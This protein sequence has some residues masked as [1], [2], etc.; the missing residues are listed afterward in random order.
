[1]S[2]YQPNLF[3]PGA[4]KSGTTT[5]HDLLNFH[6]DICMSSNKEPGYW[7]DQLLDNYDDEKKEWYSNLFINK[8]VSITGESSTSYMF[9]PGFIDNIKSHYKSSPKFIFILRN[10][11]DRCYSHFWWM[12]GLGL[13]K[14]KLEGAIKKDYNR[15]FELY[16]YYPDYYYHFGLYGKWLSSF[17]ES[18]DKKNIKIITLENLKENRLETLN[19]CFEF[20]GLKTLDNIP[21]IISNKTYKLKYPWL[22][23]LNKKTIQ[24]RFKFTKVT[25]YLITKNGVEYIRS[26]LKTITFLNKSQDFS[27]PEITSNQREWL[28]SLFLEDIKKLK[29]FT[30]MSFNEWVDFKD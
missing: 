25:K 20:L 30:G 3:V 21:E 2:H 17:Y 29:K 15:V 4:A 28:K 18:F 11:I 19:E 13:E 23:H 24:G 12:V 16:T 7:N 10:P 1:M 26:K 6:P 8:K 9:N 22:F 5:L 27:Y 14:K